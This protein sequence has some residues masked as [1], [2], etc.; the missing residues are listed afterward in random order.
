MISII[1]NYNIKWLLIG[2]IFS[3]NACSDKEESSTA[4][5]ESSSTV[6]ADVNSNNKLCQCYKEEHEKIGIDYNASMLE[7]ERYLTSNLPEYKNADTAS[8]LAYLDYLIQHNGYAHYH[9]KLD[10]SFEPMIRLDLLRSCL[11]DNEQPEIFDHTIANF[12]KIVS[13]FFSTPERETVLKNL[14]VLISTAPSYDTLLDPFLLNSAYSIHKQ[15]L[16]LLQESIQQDIRDTVIYA[17]PPP[18]PP[19]AKIVPKPREEIITEDDQENEIEES[20][21]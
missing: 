10:S 16:N 1:T 4:K 21:Q 19:P 15:E 7:F 20:Q 9:G 13:K 8:Y 17:A 11:F 18:P 14:I 12:D 2:V 6:K 5:K 3:L